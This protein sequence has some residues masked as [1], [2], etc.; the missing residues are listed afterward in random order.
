MP[1]R[2]SRVCAGC[3]Q[4]VPPGPCA[5]CQSQRQATQITLV[6][7]PPCAGKNTYVRR[8]A[9]PGDLIVDLD[10][11]KRA[12]GCTAE[13]DI[14]YPAL[15]PFA[16]DARDAILAKLLSGQHEVRRAWVIATAPT[17]A[18]RAPLRAHGARVVMLTADYATLE[19]RVRRERPPE[20]G[21]FLASWFERH[22]RIDV[23]ELV[24][25]TPRR[26]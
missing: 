22:D 24:D 20:W 15:H 11:L 25:T 23:D 2:A 7:G 6:C 17:R 1:S 12:V 19:K 10:A 14:E 21:T 9:R 13:H 5:T 3:R 8:H 4:S 18:D 16:L 26:R